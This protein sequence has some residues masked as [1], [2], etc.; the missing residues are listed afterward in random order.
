MSNHDDVP[1]MVDDNEEYVRYDDMMCTTD[2]VHPIIDDTMRAYLDNVLLEEAKKY[3]AELQD[4]EI[5]ADMVEPEMV[6]DEQFMQELEQ[7]AIDA[8]NAAAAAEEAERVAL[9]ETM[10]AAA[11]AA[12]QTA[13][14]D[15]GFQVV[16]RK[17]KKKD[18][19][20]KT[21]AQNTNT[22]PKTATPSSSSS[23]TY[24]RETA[25]V[26]KASEAEVRPK[27]PG[28]AEFP[29]CFNCSLRHDFGDCEIE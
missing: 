11:A 6:L 1:P 2:G 29:F 12:Q 22:A 24:A 25:Q 4:G 5:V 13:D 28:R 27:M 3:D 26:R 7:Q 14:D 16:D 8:E 15:D 9:E 20:T 18:K 19:N 17:N 21:N 23:T 10:K